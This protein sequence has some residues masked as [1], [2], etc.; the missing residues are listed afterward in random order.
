[1]KIVKDTA[2]FMEMLVTDGA[3]APVTG[4]SVNYAIYKSTDNSLVDSGSLTDVGNGMYQGSYSFTLTGQYRILY[5]PP[6]NYSDEVETVLVEEEFAKEATVQSMADD[7]ALIKQ[8]EIGRWKI[9]TSANQMILYKED[10]VTEIARFDLF[11]KNNTPAVSNV[12]ER[13]VV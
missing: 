8:V 13:K 4:L 3:G 5:L 9:D 11:N 6:S 10:N 2:F 7:V 12:T 1:M